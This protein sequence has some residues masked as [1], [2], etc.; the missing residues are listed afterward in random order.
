M[1]REPGTGRRQVTA[2]GKQQP[3]DTNACPLNCV[4]KNAPVR[5]IM[6]RELSLS[7]IGAGSGTTRFPDPH[8]KSVGL[9]TARPFIIESVGQ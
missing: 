6:C 3:L 7:V 5:V 8:P 1:R 2:D 9:E 4:A